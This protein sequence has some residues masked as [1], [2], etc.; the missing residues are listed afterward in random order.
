M[1]SNQEIEQESEYKL[2][3]GDF[4]P[5]LGQISYNLRNFNEIT[6]SQMSQISGS[7]ASGIPPRIQA[8]RIVLTVYNLSIIYGF[9]QSGVSLVD[10]LYDI[11]K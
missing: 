11:F 8:R 9:I 2:R 7:S 4:V 5:I 1:D 10:K 6:D 3:K